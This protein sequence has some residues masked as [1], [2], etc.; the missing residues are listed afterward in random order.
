MCDLLLDRAAPLEEAEL[1]SE[2][3]QPQGNPQHAINHSLTFS[4]CTPD[5]N[6]HVCVCMYVYIHKHVCIYSE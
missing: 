2:Y 6:M 5:C 3:E 1:T 4:M